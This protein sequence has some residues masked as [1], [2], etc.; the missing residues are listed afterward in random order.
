[1]FYS[2]NMTDKARGR[3]DK[4]GRW[5]P[6]RPYDEQT[7]EEIAEMT[8]RLSQHG[9][10]QVE[11]TEEPERKRLTL[12]QVKSKLKEAL[13][14]R[15]MLDIYS[16]AIA[17]IASELDTAAA[18]RFAV[19]LA[20][21]PLYPIMADVYAA[22]LAL[23]DTVGSEDSDGYW[24]PNEKR[25]DDPATPEELEAR[26]TEMRR[27]QAELDAEIAALP[28]VPGESLGII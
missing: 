12:K 4:D 10:R 18:T 2:K 16:D 23:D 17:M 8:E 19:A 5:W 9:F 25:G 11:S 21:T 14:A 3:Y 13:E 26:R 27:R 24:R 6:E 7:Q 22:V 20:G 15:D 1:M 28:P